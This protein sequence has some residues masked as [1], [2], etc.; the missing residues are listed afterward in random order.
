MA[1]TLAGFPF[2]LLT[3]DKDG[4]P[5]EPAAV[6]AF[7]RET[8]EKKLADLF[9]FSHGWN[10]DPAMAMS[11]YS[12]FFAEVR[13]LVDDTT[14]PKRRAA[15]IGMAGVIWP[16]IKW[17][18][19]E[20]DGGGA[21]SLD[22]GTRDLFEELKTVFVSADERAALK[23]L[24]SLLDQQKSS[25]Q[26]LEQFQVALKKLM[27]AG[28]ANQ[29]DDMESAAL[30]GK[31]GFKD[32]LTALA[33]SGQ[34]DGGAAGLGDTFGKLW[35]GA[36][37]ALRVAT[38]WKMKN[39]AGSV[40][41][42]GLGPLLGRLH[43]A[44]PDLRVHLLGHSFGARVIAYTLRGL[45]ASALSPSPVKSLFLLQG[46]FSHFAF[47]N[48]LPFDKT[49]K[50]DLAGMASRVDGPLLATHSLKDT[51]VGTAYPLASI[52]AGQDA[53]AFEDALY[54]WQAMGHDGAQAVDAK[55][56]PLGT[57]GTAYP[58]S[59]GQWLNLDGNRVIVNGGPPSGSHSDIVHPHTA[60]AALAAA[61]IV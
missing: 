54:R 52:A 31:A 21:A 59:K 37:N 19:T 43:T 27:A 33:E 6:D 22:S 2:W 34:A 60:W 10:N 13:K 32:A 11:L 45:P 42:E 35:N 1:T 29:L 39:L 26:A 50:G 5:S 61:G 57:P 7:I 8:G 53:A 38:Y 24:E 48:A 25:D 56:A 49:R 41:R 36:K 47:A 18:D 40:G 44:S 15:S 55:A 14:I 20:A 16:S 58:F 4:R 28:G 3:F 51:A 46:A 30:T 9:V 17:P 23:T 12:A